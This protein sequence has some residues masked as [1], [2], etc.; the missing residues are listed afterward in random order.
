VLHALELL[1]TGA[2][3]SV[4]PEFIFL[5]V[6]KYLRMEISLCYKYRT[7]TILGCLLR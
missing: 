4:P 3:D 7:V 5:D 2:V 6:V 1:I